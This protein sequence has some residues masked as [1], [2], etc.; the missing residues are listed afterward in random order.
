MK[1]KLT[2]LSLALIAGALAFAGCGGDDEKSGTGETGAT[3]PTP[4]QS[5]ESEAAPPPSDTTAEEPTAPGG[6]Q[7][8]KLSAEANGTLK[9]DKE[10]L[11]AKAGKVTLVM[12]NPSAVPHA[13][14]IEGNGVEAK[15]DTVTEGGTSTAGPV[16]VKAGTYE[17][18]CPVAGHRE[19]GMTGELTVK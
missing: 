9:F 18:D 19:G 2:P 7:E 15:G 13:V 12:A 6:A 3:A 14:E 16:D 8:L 11:E 17:Y 10:A 5:A 4:S 1:A